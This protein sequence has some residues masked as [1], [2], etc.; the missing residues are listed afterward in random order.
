MT[1]AR[2]VRVP[3]GTRPGP[4]RSSAYWSRAWRAGRLPEPAPTRDAARQ[5]QSRLTISGSTQRPNSIPDRTRVR[6]ADGGR[7]ARPRSPPP[8]RR[9]P[10]SSRRPGNHPSSS[11]NRSTP[12]PAAP[13]ASSS[14]RGRSW[15]KSTAS[16]VSS[17]SGRG[18]AWGPGRSSPWT[19][20]VSPSSPASDQPTTG[21]ASVGLTGREPHLPRPERLA[22]A[23]TPPPS[24]AA[25]PRSG[26][27]L[28]AMW[29]PQTS[30][31]RNPKARGS[32]DRAT[33]R[34]GRCARAALAYPPPDATAAAAGGA[35]APAPGE[36]EQLLGLP[37]QRGGRASSALG[38]KA[39][40]PSLR[41]CRCRDP[42]DPVRGQL[43]G[44]WSAATGPA[45]LSGSD[46]SLTAPSGGHVVD[47]DAVGGAE[48]RST[49]RREGHA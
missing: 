43:D 21:R 32:G 15:S 47:R 48:G 17:T 8:S 26:S 24:G 34:R 33:S 3:D 9:A 30:P 28:Q 12:T 20:S 10:R 45:R 36:V 49:T 14:R 23:S 1:R 35:P 40:G 11:T 29:T 44:S 42:H 37:G 7:P 46:P 13:S 16:Q 27:P 41:R 38:R 4:A 22:A 39:S 18:R 6:R 19:R 25:R 5:S 31:E 2:G